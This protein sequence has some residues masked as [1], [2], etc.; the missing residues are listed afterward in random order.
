MLLRPAETLLGLVGWRS[1]RIQSGLATP[2]AL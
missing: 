2:E 1:K